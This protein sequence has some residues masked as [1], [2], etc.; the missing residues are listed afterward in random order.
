MK[1][2]IKERLQS[3]RLREKGFSVNEIVRRVAVAKSS[4][5]TWVRNVTMSDKAR[6]RLL[7]KIKLGQVLSAER[8]RQRTQDL[9]LRYKEQ[10]STTLP[11]INDISVERIICALLYW[12][13][14]LKSI[15][16]G[17]CFT[18]SDPKLIKTFLTLLRHSFP[19]DEKKFRLCIHLHEYHDAEKQIAFW[20]KVTNIDRGQFIKP[21]R[22][23]HTGKRIKKDYPGCLS[24]RYH[25][26]DLAKR[27]LMTATAFLEKYGPI[28]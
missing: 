15:S 12:C 22:K 23:P 26:N 24:L 14:G 13:E 28:G 27:L 7:T 1:L 25:S 9:L 16:K 6:K 4:V 19:L 5:S 8:K 11:K 17:T 21:Y 18:N 10:A 3:I 2:K 20:S